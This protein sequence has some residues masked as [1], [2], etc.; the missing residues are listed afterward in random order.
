MPQR[1]GQSS[2]P[3]QNFAYLARNND[4]EIRDRARAVD[5]AREEELAARDEAMFT[6]YQEG[7]VSGAEIIQY[8]QRRINQTS[9]DSAQQ[10]KWKAALVEY[11]NSVSDQRA[12][13]EFE[14]TGNLG[15]YINHW[16]QRLSGTKSG[17]P[18]RT[19]IQAQIRKLKDEQDAKSVRR[20]AIAI[21]NKI[22]S[23]QMNTKDLIDFYKGELGDLRNGSA[24]KLSIMEQL[25]T[26]KTQWKAEKFAIAEQKIRTELGTA[27]ITPQQA[28]EQLKNLMTQTGLAD[29]NPLVYQQ[30]LEQVRVLNAMPDPGEIAALTLELQQGTIGKDA[31]LNRMYKLADKIAPY[32]AAEADLLRASAHEDVQDLETALPDPGALGVGKSTMAASVG[33]NKTFKHEYQMDGGKLSAYNCTMA[34]AAM[35]AHTMGTPG[36]TGSELRYASKDSSGGTTLTQAQAA[37]ERKGV[38]GTRARYENRI[39]FQQFKN[40]IKN[41]A[42][43]VLSGYNGSLGG[44]NSRYNASGIIAGHAIYVAAFDPKKGFFVLDPAKKNDKGQWWPA[45]VLEKFGWEGV[46]GTNYRYGQALFAPRNTVGTR[47]NGGT[48]GGTGKG[49]KGKGGKRGGDMAGGLPPHVWVNQRPSGDFVPETFIGQYAPGTQAPEI[50]AEAKMDADRNSRTLSQ[51]EIRLEEAGLASDI[52][53]IQEANAEL[54]NRQAAYHEASRWLENFAEA[55]AQEPDAEVWSVL[56]G[57][58]EQQMT[59]DD[60]TQLERELISLLDGSEVLY[61]ALDNDQGM[62]TVRNLKAHIV[63]TG[64]GIT[65]TSFAW[66]S[67][68]LANNL[69]SAM[70]N[71]TGSDPTSSMDTITEAQ[72]SLQNFIEGWDTDSAKPQT[73]AQQDIQDMADPDG[74]AVVQAHAMVAITEL[75]LN[76]DI[77]AEERVEGI[78]V[79]AGQAGIKL[80]EG[81][82]IGMNGTKPFEPGDTSYAAII[83][84]TTYT[85]N[86]NHMVERGE[87][88]WL[89]IPSGEWAGQ[90]VAVPYR[91][92]PPLP[93]VDP[94][95]GQ[96]VEVKPQD[97]LLDMQYVGD[98]YGV[99]VTKSNL[100]NSNNLP[101]YTQVIDGEEVTMRAVPRTM[102]YPGMTGLRVAEPEVFKSLTGMDVPDSGFLSGLDIEALVQRGQLTSLIDNDTLAEQPYLVDVITTAG[103]VED[104][105]QVPGRTFV[106]DPVTGKQ[107]EN[108]LPMMPPISGTPQ[109][110][111][112]LETFGTGYVGGSTNDLGQYEPDLGEEVPFGNIAGPG[113]AAASAANV[114]PEYMQDELESGGFGQDSFLV[115]DENDDVVR[116]EPS[117]PYYVEQFTTPEPTWQLLAASRAAAAQ[118]RAEEAQ[119]REEIIGARPGEG[120]LAGLPVGSLE[121]FQQ[122]GITS[123][124]QQAKEAQFDIPG[125]P[126]SP[127]IDMEPFKVPDTNLPMMKNE[128]GYFQ[129]DPVGAHEGEADYSPASKKPEPYTP[130]KP[131]PTPYNGPKPEMK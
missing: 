109:I 4:L 75:L 98:V 32:S 96:P 27:R 50:A 64:S 116:Y 45:A 106:I 102:E 58:E 125:A 69:T 35:L 79:I 66:G 103:F 15:A 94:V 7:K 124:Q 26:L 72:A 81:W 21:Q 111:G 93:G 2:D 70:A 5:R 48:T 33:V 52:D 12:A 100:R 128:F 68:V 95:T 62:Q 78:G 16:Q 56:V 22:A 31:Y 10:Q 30:K 101:Y 92:G 82:E 6:K 123:G 67:A 104:G 25:A 36:L 1:F 86:Q 108:A 129:V 115:R 83:A 85:A 71:D 87:G 46:A 57:A 18:E 20:R 39:E 13:A 29:S 97:A 24:L 84:G 117:D 3:S 54:E 107:H 40:N 73:E 76:G 61:D 17:T 110:G 55:V 14:K 60:A 99:D 105:Q 42:P 80:P 131:A 23:G 8:I 28:A 122:F 112:I 43:A 38:T 118:Q 19:E 114:S 74:E 49:R 88:E 41:G 90:V 126:S 44:A 89:Y 47:W 77:T 59:M 51:Q 9:Y 65:N 119:Q 63:E 34:A 121:T 11:K 113:V 120:G 37:L 53:T 130:P 127:E 91:D